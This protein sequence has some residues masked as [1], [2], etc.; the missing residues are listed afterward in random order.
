M[1][2][3]SC[4]TYGALNFEADA[5]FLEEKKILSTTGLE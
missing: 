1:K 3:A 2:F 4:Q 5:T